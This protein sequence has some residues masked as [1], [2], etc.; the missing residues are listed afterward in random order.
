MTIISRWGD[1]IFQSIDKDNCWDGTANGNPVPDGTYTA[2][3]RILD[4]AGKWHILSQSV[5]VLRP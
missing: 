2:V 4:G 1:T 5:Q 3:L